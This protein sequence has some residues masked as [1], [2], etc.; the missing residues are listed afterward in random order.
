MDWDLGVR[1]LAYLVGM[2]IG[3]GLIAH[4]LSGRSAPRWLWAAVAAVY[5]A[6]GIFVSEVWFG[7][8]TEEELQPNIDG[9]SRDEVLAIGVVVVA[10]AAVATRVIARTRGR[11]A[12]VEGLPTSTLRGRRPV[13]SAVGSEH[14]R[15]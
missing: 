8:A 14:E 12:G 6:V 7:D 15:D 13:R 5:F 1:G 10:V 2:S 9:L 11:S 4:L 3:F